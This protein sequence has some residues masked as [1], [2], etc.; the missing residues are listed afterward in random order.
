MSLTHFGEDVVC[1]SF[2]ETDVDHHS[3]VDLQA[4]KQVI[5]DVDK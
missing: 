5:S 3:S 4:A 2:K 1:G